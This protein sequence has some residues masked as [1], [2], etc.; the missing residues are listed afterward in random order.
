MA[1]VDP[2]DAVA[3]LKTLLDVWDAAADRMLRAVARRL[4]RGITKPGWAEE[5]TREVLALRGEL[6][7]IMDGVDRGTPDMV[8]RALTEAYQLGVRA[9]GVLSEP[10]LTSRPDLVL[11]H[12][13]RL[14]RTLT[15]VHLPVVRAHEDLY[16]QVVA[17]AEM[18]V[19]TGTLTRRDAVASIMDRLLA[20]GI[21]R[22]VDSTG[23]RWHLDSYVRMASRTAGGQAAVDG[24]LT[25]MVAA[26]RDLVLISDSPRECELCRPW[27]GKVLSISGASVGQTVGGVSVSGSLGQARSA[28]LW[29]PNCTHRADPYAPGL[30]RRVR[31]TSDPGGYA[32]Q[33][34][35]RQYERQVRELKRRL[36]VA[37][38]L[39]DPMMQR[40]LRVS[41]RNV[42]ARIN[43]H[44]D[45]TGLLRRRD[46]EQ[47]LGA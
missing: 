43:Q 11:Q 21:D 1:G 40:K 36:S 44:T 22:F 30:T 38:E 16:R 13:M 29:H 8:M 31:P 10:A 5:K 17:D 28:G 6:A 4:A 19:A 20:R 3:V 14:V 41:I 25:T 2:S 9:A 18:H 23:R 35:L 37:G 45:E 33:Q 47:P 42:G 24:Q 27:E 15:G 46:R 32:A 34:Q 39:G 12:A 7:A 26:G